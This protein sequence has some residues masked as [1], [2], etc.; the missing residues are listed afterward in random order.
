MV[1]AFA[2]AAFA[3]PVGE[4]VGP[5][6]TRF[7]YHLI[8]VEA[9][10]EEQVKIADLAYELRASRATIAELERTLDDL[11]Y[12][13][14]TDGGSFEEEAEKQGLQVRTVSV[15]AGQA[16][17]PGI[18]ESAELVDF[19][20]QAEAGDIG[21]VAEANNRLV[22]VRVAEITPEGHQP[23]D[24]VRTQVEARVKLEKKKEV[25]ARQMR[26]ARAEAGDDLDALARALGTTVRTKTA[27]QPSTT[28]V[29]GLGRDPAFAGAAFALEPGQ[30][31]AVVEGANAAFV[32]ASTDLEAPGN[33]TDDERETLRAELQQQRRRE[34]T[35]RWIASLR[36]Q[37]DVTDNR[38]VFEARRSRF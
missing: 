33:L 13:A 3:A 30:T 12:Y 7:G 6:Q 37:A 9:R 19:L 20:G 31:S 38:S 5:V 36:E 14:E 34:V 8:K 29:P 18:G 24:E 1:E 27:M 17:I 25:L 16:T 2:D 26:D 11:A 10:A 23:L 21:P 28:T 35:S 4:V 15:E 22:V 32:V